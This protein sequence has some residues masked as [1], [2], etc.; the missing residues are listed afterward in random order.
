MNLPRIQALLPD[1]WDAARLDCWGGY[2]RDARGT[3]ARTGRCKRLHQC[4][5][6]THAILYPYDSLNRVV[7]YMQSEPWN[8]ADM[9]FYTQALRFF[10]VNLGVVRNITNLTSDIPKP[11]LRQPGHDRNET[12]NGTLG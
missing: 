10:C 9:M 6:G 8:S 1:R 4:F 5:G 3:V 7:N 2:G 11:R 12:L